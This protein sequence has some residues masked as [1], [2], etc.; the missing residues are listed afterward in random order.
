ML[1][2]LK[3]KNLVSKEITKNCTCCLS[4][5]LY[6]CYT[7]NSQF[8]LNCQNC[9]LYFF[10]EPPSDKELSNYYK[11]TY[12]Q[13]H[14]KQLYDLLK[15]NYNSGFFKT[16]LNNL[17]NYHGQIQKDDS[18]ILDYG[19][20]HGFFLKAAKENGFEVYGVEYDDEVAKFNENELKIKM[21]S[22]NELENTKDNTFDIIRINHAL[23]HLPDPEKILKTLFRKLKI[24]GI[25]AISAPNFSPNIVK[26]DPTKLYDLVFPEHLFYF[27][28]RAISEL[29]SR[30]GY[31]VENSITQFANVSYCLRILGIDSES[32]IDEKNEIY[33]KLRSILENEPFFAGNNFF[34][35][36]RKKSEPKQLSTNVKTHSSFFITVLTKN[37][38]AEQDMSQI[39]SKNI[40][41]FDTNTRGHHFNIKSE[42]AQWNI[43]FPFEPHFD[44]GI[45]YTSGTISTL[46][47][48]NTS[49]SIMNSSMETLP[50]KTKILETNKIH[51]FL[52][53][54]NFSYVEKNQ[55]LFVIISGYGN[56][57]LFVSDLIVTER[58]VH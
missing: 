48:S 8:L 19:C 51:N 11:T 25:I 23:E 41:S 37:L 46:N 50:N 12:S 49:V 44:S 28:H 31:V 20:G 22:N 5:K 42:N 18:K 53:E 52:L 35:T 29:L 54:N 16:L 3:K 26:S 30:L 6:C 4:E 14:Q 33:Q 45:L 58:K 32:E 10:A 7:T 2:F 56:S 1:D 15:E 36:A 40:L 9:G 55:S 24:N 57:E 21:L 43:V 13:V 47:A 34:V 39:N 27:T 17:K 38:I